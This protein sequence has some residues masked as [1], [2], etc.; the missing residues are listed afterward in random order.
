[1]QR[2]ARESRIQYYRKAIDSMPRGLA[3][4]PLQPRVWTVADHKSQLSVALSTVLFGS[5][6]PASVSN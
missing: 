5:Q 4:E 1:M 6:S 3:R 2:Q